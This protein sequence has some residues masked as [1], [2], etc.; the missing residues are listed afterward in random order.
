LKALLLELLN[1]TERTSYSPRITKEEEDFKN[2]AV[3]MSSPIGVA[4]I[5]SGM[6]TS[7]TLGDQIESKYT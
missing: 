1:K 4:I 6:S 2:T 7:T 5:G 3:I